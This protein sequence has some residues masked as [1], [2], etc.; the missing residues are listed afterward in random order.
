MLHSESRQDCTQG[1]TA[2]A[3]TLII[4]LTILVSAC[5][6][7]NSLY[8]AEMSDDLRVSI[9]ADSAQDA[10]KYL[11]LFISNIHNSLKAD[12]LVDKYYQDGGQWIWVNTDTSFIQKAYCLADYLEQQANE[13]GF[14][15]NAFFT[16][17]IRSGASHFRLLDF[18]SAQVSVSKTMATLEYTLS[19][20]YIRFALGQ[21]YGFFEPHRVFNHLDTRKEGGYR[22]I[23]DI[24]LEQ[25]DENFTESTLKHATDDDPIAYLQSVITRHP[26]YTQ[27]KKELAKDSAGTKRKLILCNMERLRWQHIK[28]HNPNEKYIF[29]NIPAQKL[30]AI[31]PDSVFSMAI[32]CGAWKTKTPLLESEI[33]Y[34][35]IN[36]EWNIPGSILRDEVSE[37]AGDSAYFARNDYF[38]VHRNSGDTINPKNITTSQLRSGAYRVAQ[39]SGRKN[40]LGRII[41]RFK[42][43][44]DVYLHDTNNHNAFN[45]VRRTISHGCVRVQRP[46][47]LLL[48][49]L[50]NPDEWFLDKIR[51]SIDM[52]PES[53]KG[54]K[55]LKT[56]QEE[57]PGD[58][59]RLINLAYVTPKVPLSI[60]YYTYYPN[61]ETGEFETWPDRYEYDNQ[62]EK[63]IKPFLP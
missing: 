24:D 30:W 52:K 11:E 33:S 6:H 45:Y 38:I 3:A 42:N 19:K 7:F 9:L 62:I 12:K 48:F 57:H 53:I 28:Q 32:C 60:D 37:H 14:S 27:L 56:H 5:K 46:F 43:Q 4:T 15:P 50:N 58:H 21:R 47:D 59:I 25:P 39:R 63:S 16:D 13:M 10:Q 44:F 55:Y 36:P 1:H 20:A 31:R 22:I 26:V 54:K 34:L 17:S 41:F 23:Y 40:S 2:I 18:D 61:P 51:L 35:Q 29:V 49:V 8:E